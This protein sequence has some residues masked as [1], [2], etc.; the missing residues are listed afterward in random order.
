[1]RNVDRWPHGF[2]II[3]EAIVPCCVED[4]FSLV[5]NR[6][7]EVYKKMAVGHDQFVIRGGGPL[8]PGAIVDCVEHAGNQR[9]IHIY[10]VNTVEPNV[11]IPYKSE[12]TLAY[13]RSGKKEMEF[14]SV[15][16]VAYDFETAPDGGCRFR[17]SITIQLENSFT[18]FMNWMIGGFRP[19]QQHCTEEVAGLAKILV[20]E[21]SPVA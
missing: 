8:I 7:P 6:I 5:L 15:S 18:V 12:P 20:E 16:H 13:V 3:G 11:Q 14:K 21:L 19:W 9:V 1:M 4:V 17:L 10:R 2:A